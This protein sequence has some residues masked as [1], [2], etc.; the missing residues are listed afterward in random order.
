MGPNA[1]L[2]GRRRAKRG[3]YPT[4]TPLGALD[5]RG[6]HEIGS[7]IDHR[8]RWIFPFTYSGLILIMLGVAFLFF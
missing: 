5:K 7:R 3:G 4:A 2:T 6:K 1:E 8:C